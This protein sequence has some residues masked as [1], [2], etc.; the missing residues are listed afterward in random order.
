MRHSRFALTALVA[1]AMSAAFGCNELLGLGDYEKVDCAADCAAPIDAGREAET[2]SLP[3]A[4]DSP[5]VIPEVD[6][7]GPPEHRT[8]AHWPMPNPVVDGGADVANPASYDTNDA[9]TVVDKVTTLEWQLGVSD[10]LSIDKVNGYCATLRLSGQS[11]WRAPT[12]IELASIIDF[13]KS[14]AID[15][16]FG[17]A[18]V[19]ATYW[20]VSRVSGADAQYW[21]VD[22]NS[23][24]VRATDTSTVRHVRCVRGDHP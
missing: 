12:R 1:L 15:Q 22:F 16:A 18:Q 8:W 10:P 14:P 9:G 5:A 4:S 6:A 7:G 23:G 19:D 24:R 2:S 20:T 13:T 21:S 11:D 17:S 3:D